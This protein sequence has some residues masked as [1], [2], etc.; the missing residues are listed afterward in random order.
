MEITGEQLISAPRQRVWDA[1]NDP[2]VL[3]Y[4]VPGCE[5]MVRRSENELEAKVL[6]KIGPLRARFSGRVEM[7]DVNAPESCT[8]LFE[9]GAGAVGMA[10]GQARVTL[11]DAA[12]GTHLHYAAEAAIGGKLG[13]IGGRLIDASVK[14]MADDFFRSLDAQLNPQAGT[15][16]AAA[17][18]PAADAASPVSVARRPERAAHAAA[19]SAGWSGEFQRLLWFV[20][21]GAVGGALTHFI[22]F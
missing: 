12:E 7:A 17:T 4:C 13:Q 14:K 1:L 21:G 2:Q 9:G 20:L 16:T 6:T 11:K 22:R 19:F 3:L 15:A 10:Q 5:E 18:I 8:L